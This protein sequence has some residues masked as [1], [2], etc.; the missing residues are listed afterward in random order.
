M[1]RL[2]WRISLVYLAESN[3]LAGELAP[4]WLR[5]WVVVIALGIALKL[6]FGS[7]DFRFNALDVLVVL[8]IAIVPNMP[9]VRELGLRAVV[10]E[11][12]VLFYAGEMAFYELRSRWN[13]LRLS[14]LA[15]LL[16]LA[17]RAF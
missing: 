6:R 2:R 15:G 9:F 4:A 8:I 14:V 5:A 10:V 1:P 13:V 17:V 11:T 3:G 16:I 12:L 7:G